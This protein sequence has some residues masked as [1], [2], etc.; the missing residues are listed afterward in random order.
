MSRLPRGQARCDEC[1]QPFRYT[2]LIWQT[3]PR[4]C[5]IRCADRAH[6]RTVTGG[7]LPPG[8][9]ALAVDKRC[10]HC[11]RFLPIEAFGGRSPFGP[12]HDHAWCR[13]CYNARRRE[14]R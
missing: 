6:A 9:P 12:A 2:P 4:H 14:P 13:Q 5:S 8:F 11:E 1:R 3:R 7:D 10:P